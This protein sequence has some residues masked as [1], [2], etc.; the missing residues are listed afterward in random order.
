MAETASSYHVIAQ[1]AA[2]TMSNRPGPRHIEIPAD[3]PGVV[4]FL[5]GVNDPG[6]SYEHVERGLCEGLN[7]RLSRRDLRPGEYGAEFRNAKEATYKDPRFDRQKEVKYDPD[8]YQ[9]Q[10]TESAQKGQETHSMLIPFYWGYRASPSEIKG[11]EKH[12]VMLRGQYQDIH[13]NRLSK[14]FAKGGGMF[15]NATTNIP[16]MYGTG[17]QQSTGNRM[18]A[19]VGMSDYQYSS[20]SPHRRYQ[21]L[22]A[23]RLAMLILEIRRAD[24]DETITVMAHSQGTVITLLAQAMLAESKE[25]GARCADCIIMVDSPYSLGEPFL[26]Q[27]AQPSAVQYTTRGKL[28]TLLEI[29]KAVTTSPHAAP[30]LDELGAQNPKYGGRTGKGWSLTQATRIDSKDGSTHVFAERDNRGKVY[31]YFCTEDTTVGLPNVKGIGTYGVANTIDEHWNSNAQDGGQTK[32]TLKAMDALKEHRFYQRLW[33]KGG[34]MADGKPCAIGKAPP[35][36]ERVAQGPTGKAEDRLINAEGVVPPYVP[37]LYGD[38]AE[39]GTAREPGKDRPDHVL[40]DTLLGNPNARV[41][42]VIVNDAPAD[43]AL[44]GR[45]AVAAWFNGRSPDPE[46]HTAW[47]RQVSGA[48]MQLFEREETPNETRA[49]LENDR[50]KWDKNSYHSAILRDADN[51]RRVAAMDVAIGQ[52]KCLDDPDMRNLLIL[53]ADWKIDPDVMNDIMA[54]PCYNRRLLQSSRKLVEACFKYY[55]RGLFPSE[56][57]PTEPPQM[58]DRETVIDR[59]VRR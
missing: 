43:V 18:A 22:A 15:N 52:A 36:I 23:V 4:I 54:N 6:V 31:L 8:T 16:E 10:R 2:V 57:V 58:I 24:P 51:M 25:Q 17:F 59:M 35:C 46:D 32:A 30:G 47:V 28:N 55:K 48:G 40:R 13:G 45:D 7:E 9:F 33:S 1:G 21:V 3:R 14:N 42:T 37:N 5:H 26:A 56:Y 27:V 34:N 29:V 53:I 19:L 20:T 50:A 38:E 11:G 39:R 49:R 12:P 44:K 41:K